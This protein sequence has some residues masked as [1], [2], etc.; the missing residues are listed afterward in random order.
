MLSDPGA[1]LLLLD[2]GVT[3]GDIR[4]GEMTCGSEWLEQHQ[5]DWNSLADKVAYQNNDLERAGRF[6]SA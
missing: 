5:P 1:G 6:R 4:P 2:G 3:G